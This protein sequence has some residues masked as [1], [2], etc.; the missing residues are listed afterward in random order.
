MSYALNDA[1]VAEEIAGSSSVDRANLRRL[2]QNDL[3]ILAKGVLGYPDVNRDTHK[4]FCDFLVDCPKQR[5]LSLMPRSHLKSTLATITDSIRLVIKNPEHERILIASETA[6]QAEAFLKEIKGHWENGRVLRQLFPELVPE[7]FSGQGI[8]WSTKK[9]SVNRVAPHKEPHWMTIGVGGAVT[10]VHFTRIKPDDLVGIEADRSPAK[11]KETISWNGNIEP[12]LTDQHVDII[13]WTGTRWGRTDLYADIMKVYG[14]RLAVFT[15]QAIENNCIIFPQK[16]TWEE[17]N[18]LQT[19]R[20]K[21]WFAQYCNNPMAGGK[22][23]FP[24]ERVGFFRF[25][26]DFTE[27][28]FTKDGVEKRWRFDQLDR[29]IT[30]DPN[31]GSKTAENY[32]VVCVSAVS[33]DDEVFVLEIVASLFSPS[34]LVDEIFRL[35][36]RWRPRVIGIEKAGQ[37]NTDHYMKLKMEK[38]RMYFN[39]Q[40]LSPKNQHKEDRV[41]GYLEP[42][43]RGG[44]LYTLPSHTALREQIATFPDCLLWD[45]LDTLA[46]GPEV[47][48]R[49]VRVEDMESARKVISLTMRRRSRITGY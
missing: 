41:R 18:F 20:P 38:E 17:Y 3:F 11:M 22:N 23:D 15:R 25:G 1:E 27:V 6:T 37:Q 40:P 33:P 46:Y 39:V 14:D 45:E 44:Q 16:H 19:A 36:E 7:R 48:K 5:R 31:S 24:V 8:E 4:A 32:A 42:I 35:A 43:I 2:A 26:V 30:C 9:A 29:V 47:W 12:L 13:D 34:E 10:G 28:I 49:P 21:V